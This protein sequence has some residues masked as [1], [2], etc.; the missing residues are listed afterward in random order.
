[1]ARKTGGTA[2]AARRKLRKKMGAVEARRKREFT[3]RGFTLDQLLEM[4]QDQLL[5]V[6][7]ARARRRMKR[8]LTEEDQ[9]FIDKLRAADEE[10]VVRTHQRDLPI[11]PDFVG[12]KV[13]VHNGKE[14][15]QVEIKPEMIGH[16][17]GEFAMTRK[18]VKHSGP[19][20][21]ATRSSKFLPLK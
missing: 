4:P 7:P 1:M 11:L 5:S 12:K 13:A 21:G 18:A 10:E 17:F 2:R 9:V 6:L 15:V 19:G 14:F 8:G 20:V 16:Y 3:Y